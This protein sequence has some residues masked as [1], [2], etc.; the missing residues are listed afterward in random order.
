[1]G[2]TGESERSRPHDPASNL[3]ASGGALKLKH[4]PGAWR[5]F[6]RRGNFVYMGIRARYFDA[7]SA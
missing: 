1:L 2:D 6:R 4:P 7:E 3:D 5:A